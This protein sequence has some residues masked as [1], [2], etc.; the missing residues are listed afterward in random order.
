[1]APSSVSGGQDGKD[2]GDLPPSL[3]CRRGDRL[4]RRRHRRQNIRAVRSS[5]HADP[6]RGVF[7]TLL[8]HDG[9]PV[10]VDAHLERLA[11]SVSALFGVELPLDSGRAIAEGARKVRRGRLRL[12][13]VPRAG[14]METAISIAELDAVEVFPPASR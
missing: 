6:T 7:E 10:E 9:Q 12:T 14:R 5:P 3:P 2:I 11:E 4:A 13:V 1:M 8:V